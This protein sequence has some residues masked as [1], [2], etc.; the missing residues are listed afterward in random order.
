MTSR[1]ARRRTVTHSMIRLA[2][3][4]IALAAGAMLSLPVGALTLLT[5]E[6]P[7]FNYSENGKLTGLVTELVLETAKRANVPTRSRCCRGTAPTA[8]PSP[9]ATPAFSRPRDSTTARSCSSGS[10][11]TP[12][13]CGRS[14]AGAISL[15]RAHARR[16]Q[17]LSD[18]RRGQRRQGRLPARRTASPTSGSR[19]TTARTRRA[20]LFL[21]KDDPNRIDLWV[22]GY[23]GAREVA[24]AAKAADIKLVFVVR[25]IPLYLAC[26]PQT[27]PGRGEGTV[28]GGRE[29]ARGR[30]AGAAH[31]RL[32]K[33]VRAVTSRRSAARAQA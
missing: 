10:A 14:T 26:S 4:S 7:P 5:E 31:R 23:Y 21:P 3:A 29:D 1:R 19:P 30:P 15:A 18:R 28:R 22:T 33:E 9:S 27:L 25:D 16:S 17:A 13:T 11:R 8:G 32:R 2:R 20:C 6:N 24:R 12:A